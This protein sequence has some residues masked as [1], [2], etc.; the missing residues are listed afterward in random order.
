[1]REGGGGDYAASTPYCRPGLL[2]SVAVE[3]VKIADGSVA[4][5]GIEK[6]HSSGLGADWGSV[7]VNAGERTWAKFEHGYTI[8]TAESSST[9][10]L[11]HLVDSTLSS[12]KRQSWR[13]APT[14]EHACFASLFAGLGQ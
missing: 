14:R 12:G 7:G 11:P 3:A 2:S 13:R 9:Q 10:T 4:E 5:R 1:M 8:M 6:W